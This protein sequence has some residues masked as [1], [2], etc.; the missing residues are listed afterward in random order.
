MSEQMNRLPARISWSVGTV[1]TGAGLGDGLGLGLA[2]GEGDAAVLGAAGDGLG[3]AAPVHAASR[4]ATRIAGNNRSDVIRLGL[5]VIR[6]W[7]PPK[8]P[9]L[10]R[11]APL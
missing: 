4:P 11:A 10:L 5:L 2:S 7:S 3:D 8:P 9:P 6:G 1:E